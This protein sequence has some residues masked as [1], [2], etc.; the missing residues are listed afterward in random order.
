MICFLHV[1][2]Q[3]VAIPKIIANNF[4]F[5]NHFPQ[6]VEKELSISFIAHDINIKVKPEHNLHFFSI[7]IFVHDYM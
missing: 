5:N 1:I 2:Y 7:V 4:L 6:S 3:F